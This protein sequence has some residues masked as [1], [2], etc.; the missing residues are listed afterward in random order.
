M[1]I[2][3]IETK[4][5]VTHLKRVLRK[6]CDETESVNPFEFLINPGSYSQTVENLFDMSFIMKEGYAQMDVNKDTQQPVLSYV[7]PAER[8]R[9]HNNNKRTHAKTN[10]QCVIKINPDIFCNLIDVYNISQSQFER[11]DANASSNDDDNDES[12]PDSNDQ[13][14]C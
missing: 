6:K 14:E 4:S 1:I 10:G 7:S 2:V 8:T 9:R 5:R 3:Y 13:N 11:A 12:Q